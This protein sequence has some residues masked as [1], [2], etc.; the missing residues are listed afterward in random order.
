MQ[1]SEEEQEMREDD[2]LFFRDGCMSTGKCIAGCQLA[3]RWGLEPY[4]FE[5]R[6]RQ[7]FRQLQVREAANLLATLMIA[8][9]F[10]IAASCMQLNIVAPVRPSMGQQR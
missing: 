8:P 4:S 3:V 10:E 1:E 7:A 9:S 6:I 5:Q 2:L